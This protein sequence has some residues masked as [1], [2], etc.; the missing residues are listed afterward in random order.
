MR[1]LTGD[2]DIADA[3]EFD[4]A[5][6]GGTSS[7]GALI[8]EHVEQLEKTKMGLKNGDK[9]KTKSDPT[10]V[11]GKRYLDFEKAHDKAKKAEDKVNGN[12]RS[13]SVYTDKGNIINVFQEKNKTK[14]QQTI[15][16]LETGGTKVKKTKLP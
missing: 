16:F 2:I 15:W 13:E 8:H 5:G 14:T 4:K 6:K 1:L 12:E 9:G 3:A 11:G 7:A 10:V